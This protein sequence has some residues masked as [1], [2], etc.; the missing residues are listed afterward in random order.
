[1]FKIF[2]DVAIQSISAC[3]PKDE[4][5]T[6]RLF[7]QF[8]EEQMQRFIQITG[9]QKTRWTGPN[10]TA[11]DL[12]FSAANNLFMKEAIDP[13]SIDALIFACIT[14]DELTPPTSHRLQ[15]RL[16]LKKET[17]CFDLTFGCSGYIMGITHACLLINSGIAKRVLLLAG[18]TPTKVLDNNDRATLPLFGDAGTATLVEKK[19]GSEISCSTFA[20]GSG[21]ESIICDQSGYRRNPNSSPYLRMNGTD[22]FVFATREVP[23]SISFH[24]ENIKKSIDDINLYCLHQ[25]N[26]LILQAIAKKMKMRPERVLYSI[27]E[28]GNTGSASIPLS[29]CHNQNIFQNSEKKLTLL[30]GFGVGLSWGNIVCDLTETHVHPILL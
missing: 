11:A 13:A 22:V 21:A 20:D 8:G 14:P 18:E 6:S 15:N 17:F 12:C 1:M 28:F 2:S 26:T 23:K 29:I 5:L 10:E 16:F 25:A 9:I 30:S 4:R 27:S 24:L 19:I 3:V 7:T